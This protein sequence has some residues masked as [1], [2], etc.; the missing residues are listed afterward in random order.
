MR[1]ATGA[2]LPER[3]L[4]V[5]PD[6]AVQWHGGY[7]ETVRQR[8]REAQA[9]VGESTDEGGEESTDK[10][11]DARRWEAMR[12]RFD[13][14]TLNGLPT[15]PTSSKSLEALGSGGEKGSDKFCK[16]CGLP[17]TE[18]HT[19]LLC[20]LADDAGHGPGVGRAAKQ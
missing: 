10:S 17:E 1:L 12:K 13:D 3:S 18:K 14:E 6:A 20:P 5:I 2:R 7:G 9:A 11:G 16:G 15:A 19:T 4:Y 8:L